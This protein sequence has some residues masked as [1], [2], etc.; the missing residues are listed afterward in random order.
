MLPHPFGEYN[1][2]GVPER[3]PVQP[4]SK[5]K[6]EGAQ[7]EE[8]YWD[9]ARLN[10]HELAFMLFA[11]LWGCWLERTGVAA[12]RLRMRMRILKFGHQISKNHE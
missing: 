9:F 7:Q 5:R 8:S 6:V 12:I 3:Q 11:S 4:L 2:L 1:P 10:A